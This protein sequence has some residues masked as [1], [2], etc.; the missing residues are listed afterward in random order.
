MKQH[1]VELNREIPI[2]QQMGGVCSDYAGGRYK[3][4]LLHVF[5]GISDED[6]LVRLAGELRD[7]C[8]TDL[9]EGKPKPDE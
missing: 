8:G 2:A 3:S 9:I 4:L 1:L 6:Y 7:C 5:S